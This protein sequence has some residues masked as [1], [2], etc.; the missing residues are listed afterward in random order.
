MTLDQRWGKQLPKQL[1]FTLLFFC[2]TV[3]V[4]SQKSKADSLRIALKNEKIDTIKVRLMWQLA[5]AVYTY[6]PDT[7]VQLAQNALYLARHIKD[8]EGQSRSL[9]VLATTFRLIGNYPRALEL[10]FQKLELEEKRN[11]PL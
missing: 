1:L 5:K 4:R 7:A 10:S 11:A 2:L 6:N 9:G 8:T 3:E